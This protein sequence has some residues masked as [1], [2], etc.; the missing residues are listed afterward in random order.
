MS[1]TEL[2]P[3]SRTGPRADVH[4]ER[5]RPTSRRQ[6]PPVIAA[7]LALA[8]LVAALQSSATASVLRAMLVLVVVPCAVIDLRRRIIPNR[9]TGPAALVALLAG[10][11]LDSGGEPKRLLWAAITGGF[12]LIAALASPSGM[13]MGDVKLL[14]VMGLLLGPA[15]VIALLVALLG[16]ILGAAVM[17]SR[18]GVRSALKSHVPFGPYLA[19][20]GIVAALVGDAL[21]RAYLHG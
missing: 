2:K 17:S 11:A 6:S 3:A 10:L 13:G 9:I 7:V 8:A 5:T 14:G 12:L 4:A 15:V 1:S 19:V 20:G 16:N 21:I 18:R